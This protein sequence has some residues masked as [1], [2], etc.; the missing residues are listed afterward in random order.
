MATNAAEV[1]HKLFQDVDKNKDGVLTKSELRKYF[2]KHPAEKD[3]ILGSNFHWNDFFTDMDTNGD[4]KFDV[5]EFTNFLLRS[6]KL[7]ETDAPAST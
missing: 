1:A 4:N 5:D 6:S 7:K 3:R 2:K